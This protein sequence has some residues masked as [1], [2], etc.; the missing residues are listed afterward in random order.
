MEIIAITN[1]LDFSWIDLVF[2][3]PKIIFIKLSLC[4]CCKSIFDWVI[5]TFLVVPVNSICSNFGITLSVQI[6]TWDLRNVASVTWNMLSL[7]VISWS[8]NPSLSFERVIAV[9]ELLDV[10]LLLS[11]TFSF[12]IISFFKSW[13]GSDCLDVITWRFLFASSK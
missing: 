12:E 3:G 7:K 1:I 6:F 13:L 10:T 11:L 8:T 4:F 5:K 9:L 2:Q